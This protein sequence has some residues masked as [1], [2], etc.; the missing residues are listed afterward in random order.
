REDGLRG[1][2]AAGLLW[3]GARPERGRG[4]LPRRRGAADYRGRGGGVARAAEES[5]RVGRRHRGGGGQSLGM[6]I[7]F[8]GP[9]AGLMA[10]RS[11]YVRQLPGRIVGETVDATG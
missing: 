10:T 3:P 2:P 9:Y 11:D 8:G 6:P 1:D 7:A 4:A 5:G